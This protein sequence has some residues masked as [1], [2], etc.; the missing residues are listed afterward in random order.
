MILIPVIFIFLIFLIKSIHIE[1]AVFSVIFSTI[2][3]YFGFGRGLYYFY[4]SPKYLVIIHHL[5]PWRKKA[6]EIADI[7]EIVFETPYRES[8]TL[9][10]ITKDFISKKYTAGSLRNT[11]WKKLKKELKRLKIPVRDEIGF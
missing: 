10:V 1:A 8:N 9:R 4:L 6:F 5:F 11:T 3:S 2:L 7:R